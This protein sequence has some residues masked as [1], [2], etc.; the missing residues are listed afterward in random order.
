MGRGVRRYLATATCARLADDGMAV[1]VTLLALHRTG[2]AAQGAA[3]LAAWMA[4]HAVAAP[5]TGALAARA[6]G[7]GAAFHV[8][9]L[10]VFAAAIAGVALTLGRAPVPVVLAVAALGGCCGPM[11]TGGLSSVLAGLVP[12]TGARARAYALDA[13]TYN[14]AGIAAPAA[15]TTAA[16]L[17]GPGPAMATLVASAAGAAGLATTLRLP[18]GGGAGPNAR[19]EEG[20]SDGGQ[21]SGG[22]EPDARV[23]AAD[24]GP[25]GER[26]GAA[27]DRAAPACTG[28]VPGPRRWRLRTRAAA[29]D[30]KDRCPSPPGR[31]GANARPDGKAGDARPSLSE[32]AGSAGPRPGREEGRWRLR[33]LAR[34]RRPDRPDHSDRPDGSDRPDLSD[35]PDPSDHPDP[36]A[37]RPPGHGL[38][39]ELLAGLRVLWRVP[40]LRGITAATSLAFVGVGGLAPAAVLLADR[41]GYP[42]GGGVLLTVLAA[43]A[44][45]GAL[46]AARRAPG[47]S[48][49]RLAAVCLVGT[50]VALLG[51]AAAAPYPLCVALF[52][53]AGLCDGPLLAA[54]L[55]IRADHAPPAVRTQVFT[56]GAGLK[57][58]AGAAGAALTAAAASALSPAQLLAVLAALQLAGAA[59]LRGT[60]RSVRT[61]ERGA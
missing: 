47:S 23:L 7:A 8:A 22:G 55:R 37:R 61:A 30:P 29:D 2:S 13:A 52:G 51:A 16:G 10:G 15:V 11:V 12:D 57:T 42:G 1:A 41:R 28:P 50:G 59:L 53:L 38:W 3:V 24:A 35:R 27:A 4:P 54:T 33:T 14:A 58:T 17:W 5:L 21:S 20:T 39:G 46:A 40:A 48:D 31:E 36:P 34:V 49:V 56:L 60:P 19:P 43:G 9:A 6:R 25:G 18:R 45:A 26:S 32:G 44:L